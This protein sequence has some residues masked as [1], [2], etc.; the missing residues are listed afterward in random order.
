MCRKEVLT[1]CPSD[2][3]VTF[4]LRTS[5]MWTS[6]FQFSMQDHYMQLIAIIFCTNRDQLI[7][8][9]ANL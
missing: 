8:S 6:V 7:D 4:A 1:R 5:K 9:V 2:A 3:F